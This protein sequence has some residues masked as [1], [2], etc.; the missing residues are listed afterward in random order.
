MLF[1]YLF[2]DYL[3]FLFLVTGRCMLKSPIMTVNW[4]IFLFISL[5]FCFMSVKAMLLCPYK[6]SIAESFYWTNLFITMKCS[7]LS[8]IK[9][10]ASKYILA[11]KYSHTTSS[12][13]IS[14]F[15]LCLFHPNTFRLSFSLCFKCVSNE[16]HII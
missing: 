11:H 10:I 15:M 9:L 12:L 7:S 3:I 8:L 1:K 4:S 2:S 16:Q 5:K 13:F 6:F 14:V